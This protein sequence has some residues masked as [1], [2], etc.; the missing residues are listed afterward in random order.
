MNQ[1]LK[2]IVVDDHTFFRKGVIITI[3]RFKYA[4]VIGEASNGAELME[5]LLEEEPNVILMDI[6]MPLMDGIEATRKVRE[7]YP[8]IKIIVLSMYVE[9]EYLEKMI[10]VGAHG[11]LLKNADMED[12][13]RALLAI[14]Q[15]KQYFSEEFIPYFTTKYKKKSRVKAQIELTKREKEILQLIANGLTNQEIA[16][17]LNISI[18]TVTSH[19]ANIKTK[20][21]AKNT[22]SLLT[23]AVKNDLIKM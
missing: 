19:R 1:K 6:K 7:L 20:T 14:S 12:L 17:T 18:R 2:I 22:V 13:N 8:E 10:E 15:D 11:F 23:Y 5:L 4:N 3:N 16:N 9:E 21:G